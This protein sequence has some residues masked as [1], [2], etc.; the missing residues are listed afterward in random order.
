[1]KRSNLRDP[2][3]LAPLSGGTR[4]AKDPRRAVTKI[5]AATNAATSFSPL[6]VCLSSA[7]AQQMHYE[8]DP[9]R[10]KQNDGVQRTSCRRRVSYKR[11][12]KTY[13]ILKMF[14]CRLFTLTPK[15]QIYRTAKKRASKYE[16]I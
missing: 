8:D 16:P 7:Q 12:L 4:L 15:R 10:K 13:M 14:P 5:N 11:I 2:N 1:M 6:R 3:A 9:S